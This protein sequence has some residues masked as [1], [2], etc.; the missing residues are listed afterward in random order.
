MYTEQHAGAELLVLQEVKDKKKNLRGNVIRHSGVAV[1][2]E[3]DSPLA[4]TVGWLPREL[5]RTPTLLP[6]KVIWNRLREGEKQ[7]CGGWGRLCELTRVLCG[8][9]QRLGGSTVWSGAV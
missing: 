9:R 7:P 8:S 3:A 5:E 6:Y 1:V 2:A 4:T